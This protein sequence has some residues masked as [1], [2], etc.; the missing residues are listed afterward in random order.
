VPADAPTIQGAVDAAGP[1]DQVRISAGLYH[2]NVH[3]VGK[4]DLEIRGVGNVVI[5]VGDGDF[6]IRAD[7]VSD[8]I[9]SHLGVQGTATSSGILIHANSS[10]LVSK[11]HIAKVGVIAIG[12]SGHDAIIDRCSVRGDPNELSTG[13][14]LDADDSTV[15]RCR[16]K[17]CHTGIE[18]L[19]SDNTVENNRLTRINDDAVMVFSSSDES[20]RNVIARNKIRHARSGIRATGESPQTIVR[21]NSIRDVESSGISIDDESCDSVV[22]ENKVADSDYD[23]IRVSADRVILQGNRVRNARCFGIQL[24]GSKGHSVIANYV[25]YA[26]EDGMRVSAAN[27]MFVANNIRKSGWC[28]LHDTSDGDTNTYIGNSLGWACN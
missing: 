23:G 21:M 5:D 14:V 12:I 22:W 16:I 4:S 7:D 1:G 19:G 6:G 9:L 26:E 20:A 8:F 25:R 24:N 17:L 2:E 11:C 27:S 3:V 28:D 13:I 10:V 18:I 15:R